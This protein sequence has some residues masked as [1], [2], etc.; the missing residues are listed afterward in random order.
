VSLTRTPSPSLQLYSNLKEQLAAKGKDSI[1]YSLAVD[2]STDMFEIAQ[3]SL[4]IGEV[5]S[6]LCITE[7]FLGLCIMHSTS[8]E[9]DIKRGQGVLMKWGCPGTNLWD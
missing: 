7:D 4:F 8:T 9:K 6:S 1:T 2:E 5:Y 3:L